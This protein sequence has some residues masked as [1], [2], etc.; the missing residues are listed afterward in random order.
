MEENKLMQEEIKS[1]VCKIPDVLSCKVVLGDK[2]QI[3]DLH[4]LCS[5]G[6]NVKQ[7][8]R[9]IQ[10]AIS[11]KFSLQVDYKV[12]SIAQID[13]DDYKESRLK[14]ESITVM[15]MN[16]KI[17]AIVVLKDGDKIYE[18][19]SIRVKSMSNKYKAIAEATLLAIESFIN[20]NGVLYLEGIQKGK[21]SGMD[22]FL[23]LIGHAYESSDNF[24]IGSSLIKTDENEA[25]VKSILDA[26]NRKISNIV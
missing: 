8:V 20:F 6:K 23:C 11:A 19:S 22:V 18:G 3:E 26:L 2:N 25:V 4:V 9:D 1:L 16:N 21:I 13:E 5:T 7:L 14:I 17:K 10:S 15:N 12:I 24:L